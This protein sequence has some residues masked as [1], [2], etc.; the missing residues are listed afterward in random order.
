MKVIYHQFIRPSFN[1]AV[2]E[3]LL[4]QTAD[5]YFMLWRNDRSVIVGRNQNTHAEINDEFIRKNNIPVIRRLTGGGTVFHDLGN[6]NYTFITRSGGHFNDYSYFAEPVLET[7]SDIG[8][9]A[10]LSGR[11][12]LLIDTR[13]FSG[14]AQCTFGK[15]VMHHGTLMF[16]ADLSDMSGA[17]NL[18]PL[19]TQSKGIASVRSRVTNISEHLSKPLSIEQ[20]A[21]ILRDKILSVYADAVPYELTDAD[22]AAIEKLERE[23]YATYEWNFGFAQQY[24]L[25]KAARFEGGTVDVQLSIE[26]N[27]I[28]SVRIYGDYFG[29]RDVA[30]LEQALIGAQY[31]PDGVGEV[32]SKLPVEE[33]LSGV[34]ALQL[35]ELMV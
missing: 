11:N 1:L 4:K 10:Q 13:K 8:V 28:K 12:D 26:H 6:L 21:A 22:I 23:K 29:R 32:L 7:L 31:S 27:K 3:Y 35:R 30:E 17:L 16:S 19:K 20:F 14:N 24:A 9:Q 18:N 15:A 33:Y 34:T 25:S 2:E 5:D